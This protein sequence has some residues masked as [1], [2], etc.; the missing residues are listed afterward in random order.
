MRHSETDLH[1]ALLI[2]A[3][4]L[5]RSGLGAALSGALTLIGQ[6]HPDDF[7]PDSALARAADAV[8]WDL[9]VE[10]IDGLPD[11]LT[12]PTLALVMTAEEARVVLRS[13]ARG[14]LRRAV[15]PA[16][17]VAAVGALSEGMMVVDAAF[18]DALMPSPPRGVLVEPLSPREL[19]VLALMA[20]GLSN[21]EIGTRLFI[22]AHTVK[23]HVRAVCSK[24][25]ATT[26]TAAVVAA[27]RLGLLEL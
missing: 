1:H 24:L 13:G 9:G 20:D 8:V 6:L 12:V 16:R 26:R 10:G 22:S 23:F 14:A 25:D 11:G 17:I 19:E 3:D 2:S 4:P 7:H 18:S 27:A 15:E 5:A 21:R